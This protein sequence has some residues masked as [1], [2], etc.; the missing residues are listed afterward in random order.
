[1]ETPTQTKP[2]APKLQRGKYTE[3]HGD[4]ELSAG[5]FAMASRPFYVD[6]PFYML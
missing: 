3:L 4:D 1:M 6:F 5:C 2:A